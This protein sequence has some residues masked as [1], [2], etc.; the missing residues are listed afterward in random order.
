MRFGLEDGKPRTL[1]EIGDMFAVT[2]ERVRQIEARALHKLRQPYRNHMLEAY[3]QS[4]AQ[5][6]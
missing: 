5:A 2:R 6:A 1:E 3:T 4:Q